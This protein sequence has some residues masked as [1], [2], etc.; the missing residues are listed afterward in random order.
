MDSFEDL[1]LNDIDED[2]M[3][4]EEMETLYDEYLFDEILD[5]EEF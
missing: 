5:E 3:T 1:I 4:E 2:I